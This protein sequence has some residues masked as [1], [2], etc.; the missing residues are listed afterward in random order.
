MASLDRFF[1]EQ[2]GQYERKRVGQTYVAVEKGQQKVAGYYTT[3]TSPDTD[4]VGQL[5]FN[6]NGS[7]VW[8]RFFQVFSICTTPSG[9]MSGS[10]RWRMENRKFF[11][12]R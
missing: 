3:R 12:S 6:P 5:S 7:R 2:A 10:T 9:S 11:G 1:R 4:T 8:S